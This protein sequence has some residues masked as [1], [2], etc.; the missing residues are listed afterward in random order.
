MTYLGLVKIPGRYLF[1]VTSTLIAFLAAGMAAQCVA[2]LEQAGIV[3]VFSS[4]LWDTSAVLPATSAFGRVL[5]TLIGYNDQPTALQAMAYVLTLGSIF[6]LMRV[7]SPSRQKV[8]K[9]A[10]ANVAGQGSAACVRG[11]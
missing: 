2:F 8:Q 3:T 6:I 7:F 5:H 10:P 9:K 1:G 4:T 11:Q